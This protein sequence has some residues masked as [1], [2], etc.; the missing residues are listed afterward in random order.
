MSEIAQYG[1][2]SA[3]FN[4]LWLGCKPF[5]EKILEIEILCSSDSV[6]SPDFIVHFPQFAFW[7]GLHPTL[8]EFPE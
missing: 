3:N 8:T 7:L 5:Q 6:F 1:E 2:T 4:A